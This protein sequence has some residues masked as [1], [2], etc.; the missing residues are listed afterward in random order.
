M[1]SIPDIEDALPHN[2]VD[3]ALKFL[4]YFSGCSRSR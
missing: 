4:H 3:F 2:A 1:V